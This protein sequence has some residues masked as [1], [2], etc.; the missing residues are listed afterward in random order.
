M[1][2]NKT[3]FCKHKFYSEY[4]MQCFSNKSRTTNV[5]SNFIFKNWKHSG[6]SY[7]NENFE[8]KW[9]NKIVQND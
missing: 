5:E 7:K 1:V 4:F 8:Q 3:I 2:E 9:K 6:V